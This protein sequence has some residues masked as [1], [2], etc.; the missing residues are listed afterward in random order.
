ME[1]KLFDSL[2]SLNKIFYKLSKMYFFHDFSS[3]PANCSP[4]RKT[5]KEE[6]GGADFK[7]KKMDT[8]LHWLLQQRMSSDMIS[9]CS[10]T[11][12]L[13]N[14]ERYLMRLL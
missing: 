7:R 3:F 11:D 14:S 10:I 4:A 13:E 8:Y 1:E 5:T 12:L 2:F 6:D 9:L